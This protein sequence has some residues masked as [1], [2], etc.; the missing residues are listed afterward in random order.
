MCFTLI[1]IPR[2]R[3]TE[4]WN[5]GKRARVKPLR[6]TQHTVSPRFF[7]FSFFFLHLSLTIISFALP[8]ILHIVAVLYMRVSN[9]DRT[10]ISPGGLIFHS[11]S[12][13]FFLSVLKP[14]VSY[15]FS[16]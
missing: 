9:L 8:F 3:H 14:F 11:P 5:R 6:S 2:K 15:I 10:A 4:A 12:S 7:S 16:R 13:F 1:L